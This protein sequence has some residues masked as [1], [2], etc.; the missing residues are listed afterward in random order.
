MQF[1]GKPFVS[2]GF[3]PSVLLIGAGMIVGLRVSLSMLAASALLHFVVAPW[4]AGLDLANAGVTGYV[5]S[6]PLVGGGTVYNAVR[7][8]LWGGTAIMVFSSLTSLALQWKTVARSLSLFKPASKASTGGELDIEARMEAIEVPLRWMIIGM[9]PIGIGMLL[10]QILAFKIAWWAGLIA[11]AMSFVLSLVGSRSTG[12]TDTT[13]IGAMGKVMQLLFAFLSPGNTTH[14]LASAGIA[15][16]SASASSDLLTDLKSGYL[17]GANPRR[18][19]LAQFTG[20]FFGTLAVVPAWF[21]MIPNEAA[22]AEVPAARHEQGRRGACSNGMDS[23]PVSARWIIVVGA[24]LG[25]LL[26]VL[27]KLFP[28][29][30]RFMPSAMPGPGWVVYFNNALAFTIGATIAWA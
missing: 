18:Q 12:E 25:V 30:R 5:A 21:L 11:I 28:K 8:G 16:N 10:V 27:E 14:N 7:W 17:L 24:L 6:I 1:N 23:L 19:F 26:P 3:E 13:P 20:I 4:L 15:A 22:P 29:A 9:I 2:L